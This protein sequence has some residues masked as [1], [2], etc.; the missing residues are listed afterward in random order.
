[1]I[2]GDLDRIDMLEE[3][4]RIQEERNKSLTDQVG[5]LEGENA[6]LK[7]KLQTNIVEAVGMLVPF[8]QK[9]TNMG[10]ATGGDA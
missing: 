3:A 5:K 10:F 1:M 2:T 9:T 8:L 6:L 4:L 7:Y